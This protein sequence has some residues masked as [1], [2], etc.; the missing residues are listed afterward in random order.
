[1]PGDTTVAP[2]ATASGTVRWSCGKSASSSARLKAL[3]NSRAVPYRSSGA[4]A[5]ARCS[6]RSTDAGRLGFS[7]RI[8]GGGVYI[9]L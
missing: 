2:G 9:C 8:G 3:A 5:S 6:T 4:F 1:M 7:S